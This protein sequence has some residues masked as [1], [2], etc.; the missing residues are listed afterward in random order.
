MGR[1]RIIGRVGVGELLGSKE[2]SFGSD[3]TLIFDGSQV[4]ANAEVLERVSN[5]TS[6]SSA[7]YLNPTTPFQGKKTLNAK[8]RMRF[9]VVLC[10]VAF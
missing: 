5:T 9:F 3:V 4:A 10:V 7:G 6:P 1:F 8:E 2:P